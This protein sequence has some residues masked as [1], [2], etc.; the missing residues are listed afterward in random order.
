MD[1]ASV[2]KDVKRS[3]L[4]E[5][6]YY[7][8]LTRSLEDRITPCTGRV[9]SSAASIPAM[10]WKPSPSVMPPLWNRTM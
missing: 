3:D 4:L 2:A 7:L 8:R 5:M 6:Y 1:P 10:E 9:G